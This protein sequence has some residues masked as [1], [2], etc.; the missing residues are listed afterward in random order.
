MKAQIRFAM[1][2][3]VGPWLMIPGLGLEIANFLQRGMP[4]RGEGMWT[5]DWFAIALFILGPLCAGAAAV[6]AARLSRPGNI[7]LVVSVPGT[8]RAYVR[9]A[10]WTA[11]PLVVLHLLAIAAGLVV[12]QVNR[13]SV[14][15]LPMLA[16]ALIQCAALIWFAAVGS[17]IGRF[18]NTLLAGLLGGAAGFIL[19]YVIG[20]AWSGTEFQLLALGA[21]TVTLLGRAYNSAYLLGQAV[22]F[23][24]TSVLFLLL[25]L[26]MRSGLRIPR[27]TGAAA[28]LLAVGIVALAPIV[29][30][31]NREVDD[32]QAPTYCQGN[33]PQVCM[34]Y[35]HRRYADLVYPRI[36]T[37][38]KAA[39]ASGYQDFVPQ[40]I[41][42]QSRTYRPGGPGVRSLWLPAEVYE[43][44]QLPLD[45]MAY[46]LLVP[47][48]CGWLSSSSPP[49][50]EFDEPFFSLL[51]TWLQLAGQP[52][53]HAPVSYRMLSSAEVTRYLNAFASC[54][55][56]GL[57]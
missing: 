42:E 46:F 48:Q 28:A 49:P 37:L 57:R 45:Q 29:L 22:V 32:P 21:A 34:F 23:A 16:A 24:I 41:I 51:A 39:Q 43:Q 35:E 12:G 25:P 5:V 47:V 31:S 3:L 44:G 56:G 10:L 50:A 15:W 52:L 11:G 9:A 33:E 30:P 1:R 55:L 13:P 7:H 14:G 6:D 2:T 8:S 4:W 19:S 18:S 53:E 26:R 38:A 54:D 20:D 17:A 27:A 40:K 36:E